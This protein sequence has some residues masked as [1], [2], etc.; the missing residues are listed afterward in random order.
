MCLCLKDRKR[1]HRYS[2][3]RFAAQ[4][5]VSE[6]T[7]KRTPEVCTAQRWEEI[8]AFVARGCCEEVLTHMRVHQRTD[9]FCVSTQLSAINDRI[10]ST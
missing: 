5:G 1:M 9:N 3:T 6:R 7:A 10:V 8:I 2:N 4:Q